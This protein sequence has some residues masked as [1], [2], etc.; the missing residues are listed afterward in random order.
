MMKIAS[1]IYSYILLASSVVFCFWGTFGFIEYFSG[2][3]I[4]IALQNPNFPA[5]TQFIHWVLVSLKG[6]VFL[7][8]YLKRWKYT[9]NVMVVIYASLATM[10]FIQTFD[11]MTRDDRYISYVGELT[12]YTI[13][14]IYLFRSKR[15]QGHFGRA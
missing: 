6:F 8:G 5:G 1:L 13:A 7:G 12:S 9:P 2:R 15:M 10:C 11:F 4:L 3:P 14:S